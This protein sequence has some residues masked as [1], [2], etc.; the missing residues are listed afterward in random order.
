MV[1]ENVSEFE[2]KHVSVVTNRLAFAVANFAVSQE[3]FILDGKIPY[4][5]L[6]VE[7]IGESIVAVSNSLGFR[8]EE[9]L[10]SNVI[11]LEDRYTRNVTKG[12]GDSR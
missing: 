2:L 4:A 12:T 11:K 6:G 7:K 9:T 8:L 10:E 5:P 3:D 1:T